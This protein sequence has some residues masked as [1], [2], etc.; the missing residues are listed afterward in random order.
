M[1]DRNI[2]FRE[3]EAPLIRL[4]YDAYQQSAREDLEKN[5]FSQ[6]GHARNW[7][8]FSDYSFDE[9][10]ANAVLTFSFYPYVMDIE[11][12]SG[13]IKAVA[14]K[15]IKNSADVSKE[16]IVFLKEMPFLSFSIIVSNYRYLFNETN[17]QLKQSMLHSMRQLQ[18][19]IPGWT[20]QNPERKADHDEFAKSVRSTIK[21][22]EEN[23][24]ISLLRNLFMITSIGSILSSIICNRTNAKIMGWFSDRDS[25]HDFERAFASHLFHTQFIQ[26][27]HNQKCKFLSAPA[28]STS[29][30]WYGEMIKVPDFITGALA[31]Y[32]LENFTSTHKKFGPLLRDF[33]AGND[34]NLVIFQIDFAAA[35]WSRIKLGIKNSGDQPL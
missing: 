11:K 35:N 13:I 22:I 3:D 31:D 1:D 28:S 18:E 21:L 12:M 15:E 23:K 6:W 33:I 32:H 19:F 4:I 7:R 34:S 14:P 5:Y 25:I 29:K 16:F 2:Q 8:C 24:K 10:K 17:E 30:E 20:L 26:H 9:K 27:L